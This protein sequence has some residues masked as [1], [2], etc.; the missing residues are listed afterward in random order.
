MS[1]P[2]S[3]ADITGPDAVPAPEAERQVAVMLALA[4]VPAGPD[5]VAALARHVAS[6]RAAVAAMHDVSECRYGRP[7]LLFSAQPSLSDWGD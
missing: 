2:D 4:G 6:T 3:D 7:A 1:A 5:E